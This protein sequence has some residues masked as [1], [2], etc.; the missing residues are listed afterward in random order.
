MDLAASLDRN[1]MPGGPGYPG[2]LPQVAG[3]GRDVVFC[4]RDRGC[5]HLYS[6]SARGRRAA[7]ARL[8]AGHR[9]QRG[10]GR[11]L[12]DGGRDVDA[13]VVRR[14]RR[15]RPG[16][17]RSRDPH[18]PRPRSGGDRAL[19]ARGA[20]VHD[21]GRHR[22]PGLAGA[23]SR[24]GRP[25]AAAARH[26]RRAAQ[27]VERRRRFDPPLPPGARGARL[28]GAAAEPARQR[29]LRRGLLPG[30]PRG[31]GAS[32]TRGTSSSRS[33]PSSPKGSPTRIGWPSPATATAGT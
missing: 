29:R 12:T 31:R 19:P 10:L 6:R 9:R 11:R 20:R 18:R 3:N 17:Q 4:V 2:A 26:P 13:D 14:G 16:R 7:A 25:A 23:R 24:G 8:R 27:R 22:R 5:T 30:G 28:G 1:V 21:L 15:R 32:R 33:T